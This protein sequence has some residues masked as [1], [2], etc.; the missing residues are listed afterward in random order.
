MVVTARSARLFGIVSVDVMRA[1]QI[2]NR[3]AASKQS[4]SITFESW[5]VGVGDQTDPQPT[6][7]HEPSNP[8][9][10]SS[11]KL[12]FETREE[13]HRSSYY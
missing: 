12:I 6:R 3:M 1:W 13:V 7:N 8:N 2:M 9:L 10:V 4:I 5:R 11:T